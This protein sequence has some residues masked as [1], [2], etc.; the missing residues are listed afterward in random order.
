MALSLKYLIEQL[1]IVDP[2]IIDLRI[3]VISSLGN[4]L[5]MRNI[6]NRQCENR[7][8]T[9]CYSCEDHGICS[10]VTGIAHLDL[11]E[12]NTAIKELEDGNQHF[13][14]K[15]ETWNSIIGLVLLGKAHEKNGNG[16][17]A[18]IEYKKALRLLTESYIRFHANDYAELDRARFLENELNAQVTQPFS[19]RPSVAVHAQPDHRD[20]NPNLKSGEYTRAHLSLFS[21][22]IYG[23]VTA[24]TDGEVH[25]NPV[26]NTSTIVDK[27]EL[28]GRMFDLFSISHPLSHDRQV[29][30]IPQESYGWAKVRG[31][32][33]NGWEIPLNEND[34]VLLRESQT[35]NHNDFVVV[36]SRDPSGD[37]MYLVKKYDERD[38]Q[39]LSKSTDTTRSYD[40]IPVDDDHKIFGVV[41]AVAKPLNSAI[42]SQAPA[43]L[44]LKQ[45]PVGDQLLE[46][47]GL[48]NKL[49]TRALGDKEKLKRLIAEAFKKAPYESRLGLLKI[50][51]EE[52]I[53]DGNRG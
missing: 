35:A 31:M 3:W 45:A 36:S 1:E 43:M 30:L 27:V 48:Y 16:H 22:P 11:G 41:I 21:L 40:P 20:T 23:T 26:E 50:V 51:D 14:S 8:Q 7:D 9:N 4:P 39:F 17:Q 19:P 18:L 12:I 34:F 29:T 25:I 38:E 52:W 42:S 47:R 53:A 24:G 37:F 33:M 5:V 15:D 49:L 46:E 10:V 13:R 6:L 32:S 44:N 28:E 2:E